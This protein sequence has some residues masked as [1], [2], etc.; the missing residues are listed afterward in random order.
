MVLSL[1]WLNEI[2]AWFSTENLPLVLLFGSGILAIS[3]LLLALTHWGHSRPV[4]KCVVLSVVAHVLL[5]GYAYG[6]RLFDETQTEVKETADAD[7][8]ELQVTL[9]DDYGEEKT[10]Q[11]AEDEI[12]PSP[13]PNTELHLPSIAPLMRPEIDSELV[14]E[15]PDLALPEQSTELPNQFDLPEDSPNADL[16]ELMAPNDVA[17][18]PEAKIIDPESI[19]VRRQ[20]VVASEEPSKIE[21]DSDLARTPVDEVPLL[22]QTF[23][24]STNP[25][26]G[27]LALTPTLP[28][29]AMAPRFD[30]VGQAKPLPRPTKR[31]SH[32]SEMRVVRRTRRLGDGQPMPAIYSLRNPSERK[33][34]ASQRG[35]SIQTESA[36]DAALVWLAQN[37]AA[38][39]SWDPMAHGAG[40]EERVFGHNRE[41][42]GAKAD[43]GITGLATLAFLAAGHTHLEGEYQTVVRNALDF[44]VRSQRTNGDLSGD[45]KL[46][47]KMYCH[48]MSLL[49][50]SEALAMTGDQQLLTAVNRGVNFS[51]YAQ[52]RTDGGW[53]YQPG[54]SGDMSQ[55]GW[56]VMALKSAKLG[57]VDVNPKTWKRMK[58]FLESCSSG[59][60]NG[61]ASY[62]PN[63]GPSTAMTAEALLCRYFLENSVAP[64]T[65]AEAQRA[66]SKEM[67][68]PKNV[69]LYYWYYGTLSMYHS[70]GPEWE[71]WNRELKNTLLPMQIKTGK[72]KGSYPANGRWGGYGGRV[73]STAVAT[74][75]LE[76]YYRYL[77]L[78]QQLAEHESDDVIN[79]R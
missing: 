78:Y 45:A 44:L 36:V 73:Y 75:N 24:T 39:G 30:A 25:L 57:G 42:A 40:R 20:K 56:Q 37:Q 23:D 22:E 47:A 31:V 11:V 2:S 14:V 54:D 58:S 49:A 79:L 65:L 34:I 3:L 12:S 18:L 52:N 63:Q 4:W 38:D 13:M 67:P 74:L 16:P 17:L 6:T 26:P 60:G 50:I 46:F 51:E 72:Q 32:T 71:R 61:L 5:M 33:R 35:G 76:V 7:H 77:P 55:F 43:T 28:K 21:F 41:G 8:E 9:I 64:M 59:V 66:I 1:A 29:P 69:N 27:E 62:R 53:R 70:G 68:T 19:D 15:V 10:T 48:S